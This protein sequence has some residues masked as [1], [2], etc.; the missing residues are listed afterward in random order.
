MSTTEPMRAPAECRVFRCVY[1]GRVPFYDIPTLRE[2]EQYVCR[3][4]E[5]RVMD[6]VKARREHG[7]R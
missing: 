1:C 5:I 7:D 3:T 4:R 2:H 6:W